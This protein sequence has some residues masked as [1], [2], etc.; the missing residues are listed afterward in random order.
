MANY[1][2][3]THSQPETAGA[4]PAN[5]VLI[6]KPKDGYVARA[7]DFSIH[8]AT[9]GTGADINKWTGGDLTSISAVSAVRFYDV[10]GYHWAYDNSTN[11][12]PY[13]YATNNWVYVDVRIDDSFNIGANTIVN[14]DID[15]DAVLAQNATM[16]IP[17][18]LTFFSN[19]VAAN[20]SVSNILTGLSFTTDADG[21]STLSGTIEVENADGDD[22]AEIGTLSLTTDEDS[23]S[24]AGFDTES[25]NSNNE[26][27]SENT[28]VLEEVE[29]VIEGNTDDGDIGDDSGFDNSNPYDTGGNL[30]P[31]SHHGTPHHAQLIITPKT[32]DNDET[33]QLPTDSGFRILINTQDPPKLYS[34]NTVNI[35]GRAVTPPRKVTTK[36]VR[37]I[38][39]GKSQVS[40]RGDRR[41]IKVYGDIGA[42]FEVKVY[43]DTDSSGHLDVGESADILSTGTLTIANT[44]TTSKGQGVNQFYVTF[45]ASASNKQYGLNIDAVGT[46]TNIGGSVT[47]GVGDNWDYTFNQYISPV[48]TITPTTSDGNATYN[49]G[50]WQTPLTITKIGKVNAKGSELNHLKDRG[51]KIDLSWTLTSADG[52]TFTDGGKLGILFDNSSGSGLTTNSQHASNGGT[53]LELVT[54]S[55]TGAGTSSIILAAEFRVETWGTSNVAMEIPLQQLFTES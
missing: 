9:R 16:A 27:G 24:L 6:I 34:R 15:G 26:D 40:S 1:T 49:G 22:Y 25:S 32:V 5:K 36:I 52:G 11:S 2:I 35:F 43:T 18:H 13:G 3:V 4:H 19:L 45:P 14:L 37:S 7:K 30:N 51:D 17:I 53:R 20:Y 39:F 10:P 54:S 55:L 48:L 21:N 29:V 46:S 42:T 38:E 33:E 12:I 47:R 8:N 44:S 41:L 28:P 23:E 50:G 31:L